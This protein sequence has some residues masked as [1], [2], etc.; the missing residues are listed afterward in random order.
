MREMAKNNDLRTLKQ[1]LQILT[2]S[3][4][5]KKLFNAVKKGMG[6]KREYRKFYRTF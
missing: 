3:D 4:T 2:D 5:S 6:I 1:V